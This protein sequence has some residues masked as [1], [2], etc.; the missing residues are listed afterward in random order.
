VTAR[1]ALGLD[2]DASASDQHTYLKAGWA[3]VAK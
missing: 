2:E 1:V 3:V